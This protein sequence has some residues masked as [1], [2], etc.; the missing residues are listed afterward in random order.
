MW[1]PLPYEE[2]YQ[3]ITNL[4]I[5]SPVSYRI[6]REKQYGD[7]YAYMVVS[8]ARPKLRLTSV[9]RFTCSGSSTGSLWTTR[10]N[11]PEKPAIA[12]AR[13]LQPDRLVP[14]DGEIGKFSQQETQGA[15]APLDKARRHL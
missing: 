9:F 14:I 1:I 12:T 7:R 15:V 4:K 11:A 2:T 13:F 6:E 8:A 5:E 10:M 3:S